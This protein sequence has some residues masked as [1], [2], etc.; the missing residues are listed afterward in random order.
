MTMIIAKE[1]LKQYITRAER[2]ETEKSQLNDDI[3]EVFA[4]AKASGY[5]VKTI[6][7]ILKLKK[8]DK[9]KLAEIDAMLE[10]YRQACDL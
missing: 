1:Q 6:K 4:E 7:Q 9:D 2:L 10:L 3:K 8:L 5:D